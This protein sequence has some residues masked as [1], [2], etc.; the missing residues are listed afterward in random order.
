MAAWPMHL[1]RWAPGVHLRSSLPLERAWGDHR[2]HWEL[3][4]EYLEV[5][6]KVVGLWAGGAEVGVALCEWE[7]LERAD[8]VVD[9]LVDV[10]D[11]LVFLY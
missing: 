9:W 11:G 5:V 1:G 10:H 6:M 2:A 3:V 8:L 7:E 4:R